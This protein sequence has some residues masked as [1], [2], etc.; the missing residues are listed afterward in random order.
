MVLPR[1]DGRLPAF[2]EEHRQAPF[3]GRFRGVSIA[4]VE[5]TLLDS[6]MA[7]LALRELSGGLDDDDIPTLW[8][9][10][11]DL[12]KVLPVIADDYCRSYY[13]RLRVIAGL[14][15]PGYLPSAS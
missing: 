13:A 15:A 8:A 2:W 6:Y 9:C 4:G 1:P 14:I 5:L 7:G 11:A 10:I 3:P 12:D